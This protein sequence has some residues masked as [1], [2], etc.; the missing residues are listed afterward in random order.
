MCTIPLQNLTLSWINSIFGNGNTPLAYNGNPISPVWQS[1][2]IALGGLI[3]ASWSLACQVV[4][5]V[6]YTTLTFSGFGGTTCAGS[7]AQCTGT[8]PGGSGA[9]SL[10]LVAGYTCGPAISITWDAS[11]GVTTYCSNATAS[12]FTS[13]SVTI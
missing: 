10:N 11:S 8:V 3:S 7:P 5:G 6:S 9:T 4:L 1:A 2:C 12:G 13:F